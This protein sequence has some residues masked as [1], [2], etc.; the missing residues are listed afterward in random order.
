M[1]PDKPPRVVSFGVNQPGVVPADEQVDERN[2][3]N[4][5]QESGDVHPAVCQLEV[6]LV[7]ED[8]VDDVR[9]SGLNPIVEGCFDRGI[10]WAAV[11]EGGLA[12]RY[13]D[14]C[15]TEIAGIF[16]LEVEGVKAA[17]CADYFGAAAAN[18][19]QIFSRNEVHNFVIEL[20]VQ[21]PLVSAVLDVILVARVQYVLASHDP[22]V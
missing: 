3:S 21:N 9:Q 15:Q 1:S 7:I 2:S 14:P 8:L 13:F 6:I 16:Y 10:E 20:D 4:P 22:E 17:F 12:D 5:C 19:M 18:R 11:L